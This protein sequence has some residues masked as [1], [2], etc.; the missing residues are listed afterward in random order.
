MVENQRKPRRLSYLDNV[1]FKP[2]KMKLRIKN[3]I[4]S[5]TMIRPCFDDKE[6]IFN[7]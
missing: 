6:A 3:R 1:F 4:K 7:Q 5:K 2:S